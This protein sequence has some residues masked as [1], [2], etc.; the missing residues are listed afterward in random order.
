MKEAVIH[1]I[2]DSRLGLYI[3]H[4][5]FHKDKKICCFVTLFLFKD[6]LLLLLAN[7]LWDAIKPNRKGSR[8]ENPKTLR[9]ESFA[10]V[11]R[12]SFLL[13]PSCFHCYRTDTT[14]PKQEIVWQYATV[15]FLL[16]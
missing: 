6:Y 10:A 14:L 12:S 5:G 8:C 9:S 13:G 3:P 1:S 15:I 16:S 4:A 7:R 11:W 2:W